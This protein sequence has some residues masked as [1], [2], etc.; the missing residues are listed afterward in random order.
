LLLMGQAA[1]GVMA[2]ICAAGCTGWLLHR[3]KRVKR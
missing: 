2:L 1:I 3:L